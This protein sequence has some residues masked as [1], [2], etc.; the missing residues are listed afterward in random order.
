MHILLGFHS[1]FMNVGL[2][3]KF[4]Y[5]A[6]GDMKVASDIAKKIVYINIIPMIVSFII[7]DLGFTIVMIVL[8]WKRI[9]P[10]SNLWK[11]IMATLCNPL[12]C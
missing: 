6:Y 1:I 8:I 12:L 2:I 10:L 3:F 7:C 11:R 4:V 5:E 9:I